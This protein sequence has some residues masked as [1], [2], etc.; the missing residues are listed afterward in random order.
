MSTKRSFGNA[1][2]IGLLESCTIVESH[3]IPVGFTMISTLFQRRMCNAHYCSEKLRRKC[4]I[5]LE[6][7]N[8]Q[9]KYVVGN[10]KCQ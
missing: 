3:E 8:K 2:I 7:K 10:E 4:Y 9:G 1:G 6:I 5:R